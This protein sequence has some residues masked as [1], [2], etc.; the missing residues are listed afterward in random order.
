MKAIKIKERIERREQ[1]EEKKKTNYYRF[2]CRIFRY[3][4]N[5]VFCL[6]LV[7]IVSTLEG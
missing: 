1:E 3:S 2:F 5:L 6:F 7:F 4:L